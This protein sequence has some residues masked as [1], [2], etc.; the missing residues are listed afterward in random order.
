MASVEP[1]LRVGERI[2]LVMSED[3]RAFCLLAIPLIVIPFVL[4]LVSLI[5]GIRTGKFFLATVMFF[6]SCLPVYTI[7]GILYYLIKQSFFVITNQRVIRV[8]FG[9]RKFVT[10]SCER[11][12]LMAVKAK[13]GCVVLVRRG[14]NGLRLRTSNPENLAHKLKTIWELA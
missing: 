13:N 4:E 2:E 12:N 11:G 8:F 5:A 9:P 14:L 10:T 3:A 6:F 1:S 7:L